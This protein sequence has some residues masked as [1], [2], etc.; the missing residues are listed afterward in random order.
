MK[1][2]GVMIIMLAF[3]LSIS[4]CAKNSGSSG[5][6]PTGLMSANQVNKA[7]VRMVVYQIAGYGHL[8]MS[9]LQPLR[10]VPKEITSQG[11]IQS[12]VDALN[13]PTGKAFTRMARN[14]RLAVVGQN[15]QVV[16]YGI[17]GYTN[18][19]CDITAQDS[20]S[21]LM[22]ALRAATTR[23]QVVKLTLAS[24]VQS[25]SYHDAGGTTR[26]V[27]VGNQALQELLGQYSPLVLKGN[28]RCKMGEMRQLIQH[29]PR[30][31]TI[32]LTK[33]D[34]FEAIVGAKDSEWP[35]NVYD[36]NS[37]LERVNFD[38][39]TIFSEGNGLARFVFTDTRSNECLF[40]DSIGALKLVKEAQGRKP[41][42]YGPD[43]FD[44]VVSETKKQ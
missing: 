26:S 5:A 18:Q 28:R 43:L 16:M 3:T 40:T 11:D 17:A 37:R 34:A 8:P 21:K 15:G 20:S 36:T 2:M 23:A 9:P 33:P 32:K 7:N 12:I 13:Q 14:N 30:F 39:I 22:P 41:P 6:L 31:L 42:V 25:V 38:A 24:P 10:G 4:G 27:S 44:E 35:P 29:T 1:T 19:G